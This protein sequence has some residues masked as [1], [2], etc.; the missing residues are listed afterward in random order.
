M[1]NNKILDKFKALLKEQYPT[2]PARF[3]DE[4]IPIFSPRKEK[5]RSIDKYDKDFEIVDLYTG[6]YAFGY[7]LLNRG[8]TESLYR[9]VNNFL[10]T[11][12]DRNKEYSVLDIGCGV[13]RTLYDC[14]ELYSKSFFIGMDYA[15][16][17]VRRAKQILLDGGNIE[18]DLSKRGLGVVSLECKNLK[19]VFIAQGSVLNLPFKP[20]SFDCVINT[21]LIDRVSNPQAAIRQ[22]IS[23]LKS[24]GHFIFTDPLN[25]E[26][27]ERWFEMGDKTKI[28]EI[29]NKQGI[30]IKE[31]FDGLI[32]RELQDIR[33]NYKD[34]MTLVIHGIKK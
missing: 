26:T 3:L 31:W 13:G 11:N 17:M 4:T 33:G 18:I 5:E 2:D 28:L 34:W 27:K 32:F 8:E 1:T 14:A 19:N 16:N 22:M 30:E 21:Y 15:Y 10:L 6:I 9:I 24:G 23:V 12:F 20:N 29:L 25:F 7:K